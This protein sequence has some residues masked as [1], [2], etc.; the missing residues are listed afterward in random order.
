MTSD[1]FFLYF[2][3]AL[4]LVAFSSCTALLVAGAL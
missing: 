4:A 3:G 2:L 1:N